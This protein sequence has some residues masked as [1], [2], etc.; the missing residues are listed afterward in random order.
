LYRKKHHGASIVQSSRSLNIVN[1]HA[2]GEVGNVITSGILPIPGGSMLEKMDYINQV[3]DSLR[4]FCLNEPRGRT[5]MSV[6]LL[7]PPTRA[8]ADAG[9]IILQTDQAHAMSGSNCICVVTA[10]LECGILPMHE[11]ETIVRL[12][13]PAGLVVATASCRKGQ[14]ERVALD[15]VPSFVEQL[16]VNIEVEGLGTVKIDTAFGGC[17]YALIEATQIGLEIEPANA[18]ELAQLGNRVLLAAR[19]QCT[20]QHPEHSSLNQLVYAMFMADVEGSTNALRNATVL[21]PGRLDR[22]PCGTGSSARIATMFARGRIRVGETITMCSTINSKF[23]VTLTGAGK[24][25]DRDA[26]RTRVSG[27]GWLFGTQMLSVDPD[28]PYP[29]GYVLAD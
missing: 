4:R 21:P 5:Q 9:F 1:V 29:L 25:G 18:R 15:M 6:N 22:S 7:L 8:D 16:D 28:D 27:R 14:C 17:Y 23:S 20:V 13:L 2:E 3:D 11:P 10:L 19:E 24:I 12:D 26:V